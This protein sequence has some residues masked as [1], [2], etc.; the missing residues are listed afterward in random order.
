MGSEKLLSD[1][2]SFRQKVIT[3]NFLIRSILRELFS[4]SVFHIHDASFIFG[5]N[6][7]HYMTQ[8]GV[9]IFYHIGY[10][11]LLVTHWLKGGR[12]RGSPHYHEDGVDSL[13]VPSQKVSGPIKVHVDNKGIIDGLR[14]GEKACIEPRAGDAD[15]WKNLGRITSV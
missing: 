7:G 12:I 10:M 14:K 15:L 11:L 9:F 8:R 3:G 13:L 1:F 4:E 2:V 6:Y 5:I